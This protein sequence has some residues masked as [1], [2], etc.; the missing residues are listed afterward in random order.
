MTVSESLI[1]YEGLIFD[2]K[3][4]KYLKLIINHQQYTD[5]ITKHKNHTIPINYTR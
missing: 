5:S 1:K 2:F 4:D 3:Q